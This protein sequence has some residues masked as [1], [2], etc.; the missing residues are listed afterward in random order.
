MKLKFLLFFFAV[1]GS[2]LCLSQ[3]SSDPSENNIVS[4]GLYNPNYV[5]DMQNGIIVVGQTH[6]ADAK[7]YVQRVT[8]DGRLP[9]PGS[10]YGI[11]AIDCPH[12]Q[13]LTH[14]GQTPEGEFFLS[15]EDGG[16]YIGYGHAKFVGY[17]DEEH[18]IYDVD[19]TIQRIDSLGNRVFGSSGIKVMPGEPDST[20]RS[21]FINHWC[22]D[23]HG[24]LYVIW[25]RYHGVWGT[26]I[27]KNGVYIARINKCGQHIWGPNQLSLSTSGQY[28]PYLDSNLN[29]N[30]Y[31]FPGETTPITL[32]KFIKLHAET[33]EKMYEKDIEIGV[34]EYGFSTFHDYC[35]S[36]NHSAVFAFRDF[37][38]DTLR[39][40]KL[41]SEGNKM[42]GEEPI[43][44]TPSL[45]GYFGFDVET[46]K[47]E[48]AYVFYITHDDTFHLVHL[49]H[50]GN[51]MWEKSF[52]SILG[53]Y[54]GM[55]PNNEMISVAPNGD[56]FVLIDQKRFLT[57][58]NFEGEVLWNTVVTTRNFLTWYFGLMADNLG[59]CIVIWHELDDGFFGF[60]AQRINCDGK[61][62]GPTSVQNIPT[63]SLSEQVIVK[64]IYPN[65]FNN[66]TTIKF[67]TP[68]LKKLS[69]K[70]YNILGKEVRT[71]LNKKQGAGEYHVTWDGKDDNNHLV[72]SGIYFCQFKV[73]GKVRINKLT[74]I[75]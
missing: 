23:G 70:I 3:W 34:G 37:R 12:Q 57:K 43:T 73:N 1:L 64:S 32:D 60:R 18:E 36:D 69:I 16:C 42:W 7:I 21:Q 29:L 39:I 25:K 35:M 13:W 6:V 19:A 59:G 47:R 17:Y 51:R 71:L 10:I 8:V 44:I 20:G 74:L 11:E 41:D 48:G 15:D 65:P 62:G 28:L 45:K 27:E 9:W 54:M 26:D 58:L 67:S 24:G 31:Y 52:Y 4:W 46:D 2:N 50:N 72:V 68:H 63:H 75:R 56:I 14:D 40:Q 38:T 55:E 30:L 49:A 33:G 66:S 5:S 22:L 61:L 53:Y